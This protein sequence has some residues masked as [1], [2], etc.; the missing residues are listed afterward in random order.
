MEERFRWGGSVVRSRV[1]TVGGGSPLS[2]SHGFTGT[3]SHFR[4]RVVPV[5]NFTRG[6]TDRGGY[7][8]V[9]T[10]LRSC[11]HVVHRFIHRM[12]DLCVQCR[13]IHKLQLIG[14][15]ERLPPSFLRQLKGRGASYPQAEVIHRTR[16]RVKFHTLWITGCPQPGRATSPRAT[17]L[18]PPVRPPPGSTAHGRTDRTLARVL[19]VGPI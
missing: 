5:D 2:S 7:C 4:E 17:T 12:A 14:C 6:A 19:W 18:R 16:G 3:G 8:L 11:P 13:V 10:A 1:A 9:S 15:V